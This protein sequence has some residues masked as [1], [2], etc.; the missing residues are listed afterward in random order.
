MTKE[1]KLEA[2]ETVIAAS[3]QEAEPVTLTDTQQDQAFN[4]GKRAS[5]LQIG[6]LENLS[7]F[8]RMLGTNPTYAI[9]EQA[10]IQWTA[11]YLSDRPNIEPSSA[12]TAF[13]RFAGQLKDNFGMEFT[14]PKSDNPVA[15][16]KAEQ[17]EKKAAELLEKYENTSI[18]DLTKQREAAYL[19]LA[20]KPSDKEAKKKVAEIDKVISTKEKAENKAHSEVLK[21]LRDE[22]IELVK[23]CVNPDVL[24]SVIATLESN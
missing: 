6:I 14:K 10:R 21:T 4:C 1:N 23:K 8:A 22:A 24:D 2:S 20:K 12:D 5:N 15:K 17:R 13:T 18:G 7:T 16:A 3:I 9:F 19:T 11:G